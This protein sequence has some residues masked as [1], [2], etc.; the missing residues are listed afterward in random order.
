MGDGELGKKGYRSMINR[1]RIKHT[2]IQ[3]H[4]RSIMIENVLRKKIEV[5]TGRNNE[6]YHIQ[7]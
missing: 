3:N 1:W 4:R 7:E 5:G 6:E 2:R